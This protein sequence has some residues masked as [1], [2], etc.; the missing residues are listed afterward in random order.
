MTGQPV[1]EIIV[2]MRMTSQD[3]GNRTQTYTASDNTHSTWN[4]HKF[5][6]HKHEL[7]SLLMAKQQRHDWPRT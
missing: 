3:R 6:L 5:N 4:L 1:R 2:L 7:K